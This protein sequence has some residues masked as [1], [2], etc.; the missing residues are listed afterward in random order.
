MPNGRRR[1]HGGLGT[2]PR[3]A[4]GLERM[5]QANTIHGWYSAAATAARRQASADYR[6]F[7]AFLRDLA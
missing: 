3:T 4:E 5:R 1:L 6:T 2:G 7:K